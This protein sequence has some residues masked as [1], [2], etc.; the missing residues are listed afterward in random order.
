MSRWRPRA[1]R[2]AASSS[3]VAADYEDASR[4][5]QLLESYFKPP[6]KPKAAKKKPSTPCFPA[7]ASAQAP[8]QQQPR[9]P[10]D[11]LKAL[12]K[13]LRNASPTSQ[14]QFT[15]RL[16]DATLQ[17][18]KCAKRSA[19][20]FSRVITLCSELFAR[21]VAFRALVATNAASLYERLLDAA[22][23]PRIGTSAMSASAQLTVHVQAARAQNAQLQS[24]LAMLEAW[25]EDFG[26]KYPPIAAGHAALERRG[27]VFP[28]I[29]QKRLRDAQQDAEARQ[30][31]Q[32]IRQ[33]Q[34]EQM[35]RAAPEIEDVIVEMNR[36]F[37]I[38]V[39]TLDAFNLFDDMS[40]RAATDGHE[41]SEAGGNAAPRNKPEVNASAVTSTA[42]SDDDV[43][44]EAVE[45]EDVAGDDEAGSVEWEDVDNG[46]AKEHSDENEQRNDDDDVNFESDDDEEESDDDGATLSRLDM[47][48]IVQAYGLGSSSYQLTIE[49]PTHAGM[50]EQ[51]SD[52]EVLFRHLADGILRIRK[53]FLPLVH[54]WKQHI[55]QHDDNGS[56]GDSSSGDR[57]LA[58]RVD[59][60]QH[61]LDLIVSKWEDLVEESEKK[62]FAKIT[63]S[64][65][66]L[67]LSAYAPRR[68]AQA[69]TAGRKR[70][71]VVLLQDARRARPKQ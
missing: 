1:A 29:Q 42:I 28:H 47:N 25:K 53:R 54:E 4:F 18:L 52:N 37:D 36:I 46:E 49:I 68:K 35:E 66:S 41:D 24:V 63:P 51:S 12:K 27:F 62:R 59:D 58:Y 57:A 50:C 17:Q 65:V 60:L 64:V 39:P 38:L 8:Q 45:W 44:D 11:D 55:Q 6:V 2:T 21:S 34:I 43:D 7:T 5:E 20:V 16:F 61:R 33:A 71:R 69:R 31:R 15:T 40:P 14:S 70:Q 48:Q 26:D 9:P 67:P 10:E 3:T 13:W 56:T 19:V 30:L 22:G 23:E 32:R